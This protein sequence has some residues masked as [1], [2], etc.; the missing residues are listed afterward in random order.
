M[1]RDHSGATFTE[2]QDAVNILC[3]QEALSRDPATDQGAPIVLAMS[4]ATVRRRPSRLRVIGV[5]VAMFLCVLALLWVRGQRRPG[6]GPRRLDVGG[7]GHDHRHHHDIGV[8]VLVGLRLRHDVL[9]RPDPAG[10]MT[11]TL[12]R[13]FQSMGSE[14]SIRL[15]SATADLAAAFYARG[16]IGGRR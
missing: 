8:H 1:A 13:T 6:S 14:A 11:A 3:P 7:A 2:P 16:R 10:V 4:T 9:R 15:E 5:S 12:Q